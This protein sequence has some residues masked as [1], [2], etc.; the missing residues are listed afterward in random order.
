MGLLSSSSRE[1]F[2]PRLRAFRAGIAELGYVEGSNLKT[3][4]RWAENRYERL[5]ALA[6]DLVR[7]DV[8]LIAALG[9]TPA[10]LA[11]KQATSSIPIVF[12]VGGDPVALGLVASLRRP[13]G[14]LTGVAQMGV[15]LAVK[16]LE[17]LQ[18]LVPAAT[19]IALLVKRDNPNSTTQAADIQ[20]AAQRLALDVHV[21]EVDADN[22]LEAAVASAAKTKRPLVIAVDTLFINRSERLGALCLRFGV[23]AIFYTREFAVAGGLMSYGA[24]FA[25]SYRLAGVYAARLL[26]GEKPMNLPVQQATKVELIINLKTARELGVAI[27]LPL[28]GRADE[29]I[30]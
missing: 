30:E 15:E 18:E 4:H 25:E 24:D 10:A 13:G 23:P 29:I 3:E 27:P 21:L 11:A 1:Q 5:P 9:S 19:S 6:A 12:L 26:K 7:R 17:L 16:R 2:E 8:A 28:S 22:D 20:G 14:N